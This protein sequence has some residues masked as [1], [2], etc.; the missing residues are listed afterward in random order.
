MTAMNANIA[1]TFGRSAPVDDQATRLRQLMG[2]RRATRPVEA[3][4]AQLPTPEPVTRRAR[5]IAVTSGKG[6]VG[7]TNIAVNLAG[8]LAQAGKSVVLL[9][10]DMGL[11]N[12]DVLCGLNLTHNLAH[13]VARRRS[14]DDVLATGPGGFRLA[15]GATGLARMADLPAAE[16][17]RLLAAL[18]SLE[19]SADIILVDTGAGISPNVLSFTRSADDVLVVTTPEPTA[20]TDAYATIKV[21]LRGRQDREGGPRVSLLVNQAKGA[22]EARSVFERVAKVA[23]QFLGVAIDDAGFVPSDKAVT[24]AVRSRKPFAISEPTSPAAAAVLRLAARLEQGVVAPHK[25]GRFF[26]RL[27]HR[28]RS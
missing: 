20:V 23:A 16:H 1:N 22:S 26:G 4:P 14:L 27:A 28:I 18:D 6:G 25:A 2:Q 11:A 12:A 17:D 21:V 9:D 13:V 8:V 15:A 3:P 7:K 24:R 5:V 10:A 19:R